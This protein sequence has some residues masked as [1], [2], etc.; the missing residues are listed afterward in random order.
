M[1]ILD[2]FSFQQQDYLSRNVQD[3]IAGM[4]IVGWSQ[5]VTGPSP[6]VGH[7]LDYFFPLMEMSESVVC[8]MCCL[9]TSL[10]VEI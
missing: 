9:V 3:Y 6:V 2:N 1:L 10:L 7:A 8:Y 4:S 5:L